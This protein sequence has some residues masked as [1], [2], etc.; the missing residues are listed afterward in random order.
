MKLDQWSE[1]LE[2]GTDTGI[3]KTSVSALI[4][5]EMR[6]KGVEAVGL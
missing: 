6:K 1:L 5:E 4:I 2:T 3:R